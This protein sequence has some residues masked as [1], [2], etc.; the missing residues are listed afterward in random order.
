VRNY[1]TLLIFAFFFLSSLA[2]DGSHLWSETYDGKFEVDRYMTLFDLITKKE[3]VPSVYFNNQDIDYINDDN[4][5]TFE[6]IIDNEQFLIGTLRIAQ[7][8]ALWMPSFYLCSFS[9]ENG[10]LSSNIYLG[11]LGEDSEP[12]TAELFEDDTTKFL[13]IEKK[14][15]VIDGE[16]GLVK[17]SM[18]DS[19]V[20]IYQ[21]D[22]NGIFIEISN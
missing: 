11:Y 19:T 9:K 5:N 7:N 3:S 4:K 12:A 20:V 6:V 16:E 13:V 14:Y 8:E 10:L 15:E 17:G 22:F 18:I 2:E 21:L 1:S